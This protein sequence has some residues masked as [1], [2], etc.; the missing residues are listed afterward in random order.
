[1]NPAVNMAKRLIIDS[2][3]KSA[4]L[5]GL[6][7]TFPKTEMILNNISV[8]TSREEVLF[9]I[10]M[11]RAWQ[12]LLE[13][14]D[15]RNSLMLLREFNKIVGDNLIYGSGDL[16]TIDVSIGGTS[17]K[18]DI[19]DQTTIYSK[20]QELETIEDAELKAL[21]YFCF[22]ARSQ[23]FIDGNKRV[24]QL[25]ANKVL[26]ENGIGIFQVPIE[27]IETFTLLLISFYE[28]N[29]DTEIISFMQEYCINRV[30]GGAKSFKAEVKEITVFDNIV[31][32]RKFVMSQSQVGIM[33]SV[34]RNIRS[35]LYSYSLS[36]K[37]S[38]YEEYD[39]IVLSGEGGYVVL[40]EGNVY[41]SGVFKDKNTVILKDFVEKTVWLLT[42]KIP[43]AVKKIE[44]LV[45]N[46]RLSMGKM[47]DSENERGSIEMSLL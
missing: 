40:N 38:L 4:N 41:V 28:S 26:V 12:F 44:F 6:G 3:W 29:E 20:I 39:N 14:L 5:E 46:R 13:N 11:K 24:A 32:N 22:I 45:N 31:D 2:I 27:A 10:N 23:M 25:M 19:P 33:D 18:P 8:E 17:W 37:W 30:V 15:Y 1:M 35:L 16:R 43:F 36:G 47:F 21:K 42:A 7:T 34:L 9:V